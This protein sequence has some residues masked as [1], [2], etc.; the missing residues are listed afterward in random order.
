M[1]H[2][3]GKY[4]KSIL[5][6]KVYNMRCPV[7]KNWII[8]GNNNINSLYSVHCTV[9]IVQCTLY[10]VHCTVYIVQ[11]TLYSVHCTVYIVHCT[12]YIVH[13]TLYIA[14]CTPWD[15]PV[16]QLYCVSIINELEKVIKYI[17]HKASISGYLISKWMG[18]WRHG[19]LPN[20][21]HSP[22][23]WISHNYFRH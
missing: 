5:S 16:L 2:P 12:L 10:S 7:L 19:Y 15:A 23:S 22:D 14:Q 8:C 1:L 11:C 3:H 13:C 18:K 4:L 17:D 9:Y 6:C 20:R 21:F